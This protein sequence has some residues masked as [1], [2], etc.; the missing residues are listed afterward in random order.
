MDFIH[1]GIDETH[2][3]SAGFALGYELIE[4]FLR[5]CGRLKTFAGIDDI[6]L[7][8]FVIDNRPD[9]NL[10]DDLRTI[11]VLNDVG[12]GFID[13]E[14]DFSD[15]AGGQASPGADAVHEIAD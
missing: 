3:K 6:D 12:T 11:G 13:G 8:G 5:D 10:F 4:I 9:R 15:F 1:N 2:T 7:N 14:L